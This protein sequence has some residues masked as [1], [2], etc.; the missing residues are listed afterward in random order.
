[1]LDDKKRRELEELIVPKKNKV[2]YPFQV[3]KDQIQREIDREHCVPQGNN[4][5]VYVLECE[6]DK[7]YIGVTGNFD[8]R[9]QNHWDRTGSVFTKKHKPIRILVKKTIG[10]NKVH[11]LDEEKRMTSK[12]RLKYGPENVGG[13]F[14]KKTDTLVEKELMENALKMNRPKK[15]ITDEELEELLQL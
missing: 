13:N 12:Y 6:N 1:M 4:I 9:M 11:A 7:Y 3:I 14:S 8:R 15:T 10:S 5:C 2:L